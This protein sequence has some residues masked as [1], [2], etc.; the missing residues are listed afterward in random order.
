MLIKAALLR[1]AFFYA[2]IV[3]VCK[4]TGVRQMN[5][6]RVVITGVGAITAL[7]LDVVSTWRGVVNGTNGVHSIQHF[8]A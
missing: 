6:R 3:S 2:D 4:R 1:A 8:D 5:D 7:G